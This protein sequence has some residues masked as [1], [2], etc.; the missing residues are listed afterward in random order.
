MKDLN[1]LLAIALEA[2]DI[3]AKLMTTSAPGA[4]RAKGDRD[5]VTELDVKIQH[6]I[7]AHLHRATPDIDFLGEEEGGGT[8]D[9][10]TEYVWALDPIDGTSNFAH[11]I[12]LCAT[13]LALVHRGEPVVGV[14]VAPFLN[15][16]YHATKGGGAYCNDKPIHASE[17]TDLSRAIVSIGD[18][19][20]GPGAE[21][22][23]RRRFAV[24]QVLAENVERV[25]MFG[26]ASLDLAWVAE[27]RTDACIILSNKPWDTAAGTLVALEG[28]AATSDANGSPHNL[29]STS[30][31]A[32]SKGLEHSLHVLTSN[33]SATP[34]TLRMR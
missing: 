24:T 20:T 10:S 13:S 31:V 5:Y 2:A 14:I 22:K 17:T 6:E 7:Q 28:A 8:I 18:Y 16:R 1:D 26:A 30:T 34:N 3:G 25:R 19:A 33:V 9:E 4:V 29:D 32:A 15:L 21:E 23:N 27:G 12:P 11:G